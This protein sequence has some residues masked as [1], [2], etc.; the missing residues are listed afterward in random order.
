M[1]YVAT[2]SSC[3]GPGPSCPATGAQ[4]RAWGPSVSGQAEGCIC[5]FL[6]CVSKAAAVLRLSMYP[7]HTRG[8]TH[9]GHR[10]DLGCGYADR[11][12]QGIAPSSTHVG[13]LHQTQ[14]QTDTSPPPLGLAEAEAHRCITHATLSGFTSTRTFV[15]PPSIVMAPLPA[16]HPCLDPGPPYPPHGSPTRRL[17]QLGARCTHTW[18][19][20]YRHTTLMG[21]PEYQHR[22]SARLI[23]LPGPGSPYSLAGP[24]WSLPVSPHTHP[25]RAHF[26]AGADTCTQ[27]PTCDTRADPLTPTLN[28]YPLQ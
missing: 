22:P 21:H 12:R 13:G 1:R 5:C 23:S 19:S 8:D 26:G 17:V 15:D 24:D 16:R 9:R 11:H 7:R 18:H 28:F 2:S 10:H 6:L 4:P 14:A 27:Q 25:T 3:P 20:S